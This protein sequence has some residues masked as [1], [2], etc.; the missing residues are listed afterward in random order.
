MFLLSIKS[1]LTNISRRWTQ[2]DERKLADLKL[3]NVDNNQILKSFPSTLQ[4]FVLEDLKWFENKVLKKEARERRSIVK[5]RIEKGEKICWRTDRHSLGPAFY[6][7]QY[8][9][10]ERIWKSVSKEIKENEKNEE[11]E[12]N[13]G[14]DNYCFI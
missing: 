6:G 14:G 12:E 7:M 13:E 3:D 2:G 8:K 5:G 1:P 11:N 10:F 9:S 4:Q